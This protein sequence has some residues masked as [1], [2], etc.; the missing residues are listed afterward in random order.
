MFRILTAQKV[1]LGILSIS[2]LAGFYLTNISTLPYHIQL[3]DPAGM[4]LLYLL[5][6]LFAGLENAGEKG[7]TC[8]VG[9][10]NLNS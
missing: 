4:A 6:K 9:F 8:R 2:P 1:S 7:V 5:I 3:N 10:Y